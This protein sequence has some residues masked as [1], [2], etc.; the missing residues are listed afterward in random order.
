MATIIRKHDFRSLIAAADEDRPQTLEEKIL[1][2]AD[3]RVCHDRIVSLKRRL[4]DGR[5]R[6]FPDGKIPVHD[7]MIAQKLRTLE[8]EL[9]TK[10]S[11]K[12]TDIKEKI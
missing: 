4:E 5:K 10:A 1:Y 7:R 11:L 3:K 9:L 8:K 2:Y 12:A 6:Y